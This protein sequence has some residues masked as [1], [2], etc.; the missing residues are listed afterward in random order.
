MPDR[1]GGLNRSY[2]VLGGEKVWVTGSKFS[3]VN[4]KGQSGADPDP[5]WIR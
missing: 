3:A 4:E 1:D 5:P 2:C